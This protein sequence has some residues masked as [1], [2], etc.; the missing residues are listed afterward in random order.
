M[1]RH[2]T[3]PP[4]PILLDQTPQDIKALIFERKLRLEQNEL[5][6][7][8]DFEI[9]FDRLIFRTK[10]DRRSKEPIFENRQ[11]Y[12]LDVMHKI[13]EKYGRDKSTLLTVEAVFGH[14]LHQTQVR[15]RTAHR[16]LPEKDCDEWK[17]S[18]TV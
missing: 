10:F 15:H 11:I 13:E 16:K 9:R 8:L 7:K 1:Y 12:T 5:N 17:R 2:R 14:R 3:P 18:G 4:H 6:D